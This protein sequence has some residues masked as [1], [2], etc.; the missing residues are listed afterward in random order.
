MEHKVKSLSDSLT[1]SAENI[2]KLGL[3][4]LYTLWTYKLLLRHPLLSLSQ[5]VPSLNPVS[6]TYA[7][8]TRTRAEVLR[9]KK[10]KG[11]DRVGREMDLRHLS[12]TF[13]KEV[14]PVV[15]NSVSLRIPVSTSMEHK[16]EE[17]NQT[18]PLRT[19]GFT[20]AP[21]RNRTLVDLGHRKVGTLSETLVLSFYEREKAERKRERVGLADCFKGYKESFPFFKFST[22]YETRSGYHN[23]TQCV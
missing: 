8:L 9:R 2:K 4:S 20:L 15:I 16:M 22:I 3:T 17:E 23:F 19:V 6:K 7:S 21:R 11:V 12:D 18:V 5:A 13:V 1:G 14:S 10:F